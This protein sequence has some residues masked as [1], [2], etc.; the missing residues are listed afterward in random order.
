[1]IGPKGTEGENHV[2]ENSGIGNSGDGNDGHCGMQHGR[3]HL[4]FGW[5]HGVLSGGAKRWKDL[6]GLFFRHRQYKAG[7]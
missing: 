5:E 7:C 6:G 2:E 3:Q 4:R 1:M